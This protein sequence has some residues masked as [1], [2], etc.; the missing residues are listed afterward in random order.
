MGAC[1]GTL[2]IN[3]RPHRLK[4]HRFRF[5]RCSGYIYIFVQPMCVCG[6]VKRS[7]SIFRFQTDLHRIQVIQKRCLIRH[8]H[9]LKIH[10]FFFL[11]SRM[12]VYFRITKPFWCWFSYKRRKALSAFCETFQV[13]LRNAQRYSDMG[14][15]NCWGIKKKEK[16][17]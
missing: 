4:C 6:C 9:F 2:L 14:E 1:I 12:I 16:T 11:S 17:K 10:F 15:N 8:E 7:I 3:F 13:S 5:I